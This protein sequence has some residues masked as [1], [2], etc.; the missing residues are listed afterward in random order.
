[1]GV[2]E[3]VEDVAELETRLGLGLIEE[4]IEQANDELDLIPHMSQWKPWE[5]PEGQHP[6]RIELID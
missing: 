4:I 1:M 3:S 5:M 6:V 2:V